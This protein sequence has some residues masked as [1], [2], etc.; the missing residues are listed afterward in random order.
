MSKNPGVID[1]ASVGDG[2]RRLGACH[3][4]ADAG[5]QLAAAILPAVIF[6]ALHYQPD[7]DDP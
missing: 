5:G 7:A 3:G 1:A 2:A 6:I 4:G